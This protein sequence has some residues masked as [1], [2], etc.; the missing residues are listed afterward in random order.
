MNVIHLIKSIVGLGMLRLH[1]CWVD[2]A[3]NTA[4]HFYITSVDMHSMVDILDYKNNR[5][6]VPFFIE[7]IIVCCWISCAVRP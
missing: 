1:K 5:A 6:N 7:I 2:V 3:K 4:L